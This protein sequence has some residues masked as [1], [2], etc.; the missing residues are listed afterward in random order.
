VTTEAVATVEPGAARPFPAR[1]LPARPGV[2]RSSALGSPAVGPRPAA[3]LDATLVGRIDLT[4]AVARFVVRPDGRRDFRPGQYLTLGLDV[5]GRPVQ[6]PYS[7]ASTPGS[8]ELEFL[9]RRVPHGMLTPALWRAPLGSRLR[10]G[11]AKGLFTLVPDDDRTHLFVATG[12]G[13]APIIAMLASLGRRARRARAVVVHGV[14]N[15]SELAY[16]DRLEEACAEGS[17]RMTYLPTISRPHDPA[18]AGWDGPTGR[19][20][21][22]L[23]PLFR[24]GGLDPHGTVVYLCGNPGMIESAMDVLGQVG[25]PPEAIVTERYW[26]PPFAAGEPSVEPTRAGRGA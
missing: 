18:N 26:S 17:S 22:A 4:D 2:E 10:L 3:A 8:E 23:P 11:S 14:A 19:V 24:P 16:R 15:V 6:R 1:P 7:T 5:D 20:T 13:L 12:T 25:L 21:K 9:I